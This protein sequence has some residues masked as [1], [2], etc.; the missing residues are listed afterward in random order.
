MEVRL[1][2]LRHGHRKINK[3]QAGGNR[4]QEPSYATPCM[5]GIAAHAD[6]QYVLAHNVVPGKF[7]GMRSLAMPLLDPPGNR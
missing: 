3:P 4:R 7:V 2:I 6:P 5:I 1:L